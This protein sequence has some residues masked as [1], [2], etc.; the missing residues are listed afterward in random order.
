MNIKI[1]YDI[2]AKKKGWHYFNY[3]IACMFLPIVL[4]KVII[5][6]MSIFFPIN[7]GDAWPIILVLILLLI[8]M[9]LAIKFASLSDKAASCSIFALYDGKFYCAPKAS[10]RMMNSLLKRAFESFITTGCSNYRP[11]I[12]QMS[13]ISLIL[14]PSGEHKIT[15][16]ARS[17]DQFAT[18]PTIVTI[19]QDYT[20]YDELVK[21][22]T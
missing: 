5:D 20:D 12:E 19:N 11:Y 22:L 15:Y 17:G 7:D 2:E 16:I 18:E 6:M 4:G 10:A 14:E 13:N 9:L 1:F 3:I 8:G 21:R